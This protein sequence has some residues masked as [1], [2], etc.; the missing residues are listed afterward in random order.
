MCVCVCVCVQKVLR[1][2]M[3]LP[4]QMNEMLILFKIIS[5]EFN[6]MITKSFSLGEAPLKLHF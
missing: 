4:R 3:Y 2:K 5:L 6:T 1:R